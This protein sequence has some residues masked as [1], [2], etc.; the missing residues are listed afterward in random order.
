M[1]IYN[2]YIAAIALS[3]V[4]ASCKA[5]MATV[6]KDEVKENIPQNFNQEEQGDANNNSGT[7]P[8][9]QFLQTRI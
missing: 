5:P 2:K 9:R 3:L 7:T 1:K 8:W 6:V 4:L